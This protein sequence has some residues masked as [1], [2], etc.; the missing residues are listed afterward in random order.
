[1]SKWLQSVSDE[2]FGPVEDMVRADED[3]TKWY[4]HLGFG[5]KKDN[6]EDEEGEDKCNIF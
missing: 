2:S 1:M 3:E 4:N 6:E 5:N